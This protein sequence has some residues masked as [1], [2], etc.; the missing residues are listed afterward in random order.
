MNNAHRKSRQPFGAYAIPLF[1]LLLLTPGVSAQGPD[2]VVAQ[3]YK[4]CGTTK[5]ITD[6]DAQ[7]L[8]QFFTTGTAR[9][10]Q[11]D[12]ANLRSA[13]FDALYVTPK[14]KISGFAIA[15]PELMYNRL[16]KGNIAFVPVSFAANGLKK[17]INFVVWPTADGSWRIQTLTYDPLSVRQY[18][19]I[20]ILAQGAEAIPRGAATAEEKSLDAT[21]AGVAAANAGKPVDALAAHAEAIRLNPRSAT[22]YINRCYEYV[23]VKRFNEA[24]QDCS[25]AVTLEPKLW[26][27]YNARAGLYLL[28]GNKV[29]ALED[30]SSVIKLEGDIS[31]AFYL[32]G[33]LYKEQKKF[34][35]A[36]ADYSKVVELDFQN[37]TLPDVG[38]GN[39]YFD[40]GV[41]YYNLGDFTATVADMTEVIRLVPAFPNSYYFLGQSDLMLEN[42]SAAFTAFDS[43][44]KLSPK[45]SAGYRGRGLAAAF[46]GRHE[47]AVQDLST[48]IIS[49]PNEPTLYRARAVSYRNLG[50]NDLAAK[51]EATAQRL[52]N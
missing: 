43:F 20:E 42:Y 21:I 34:E 48:A 2:S 39:V 50:K 49:N 30:L 24:L 18:S 32:R 47:T 9:S 8:S 26:T 44:I 17:Q 33:R 29:G 40:R 11:E 51:D 7:T 25:R 5:Q 41:S 22:P 23:R 27:A 15:K 3:L 46:L 52:R 6:L 19:L 14:A 28:M 1:L 45:E 37:L 12:A 16:L 38:K 31:N 4:Y 10:I 13:N 35:L 36:I